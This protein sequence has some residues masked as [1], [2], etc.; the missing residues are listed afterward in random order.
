MIYLKH[1]E[2]AHKKQT[3]REEETVKY[4]APVFVTPL[5]DVIINEGERA[6]FEA[7]IQPVGDPNM[8]VDWFC[9]GKPITASSRVNTICQFG[10]VA[11]D[12]L[13]A[14]A[15]DSG[16]YTCEIRNESGAVHTSAKLV[17]QTRREIDAEANAARQQTLKHTEMKATQEIRREVREPPPARPEFVRQ[18]EAQVDKPE[19]GTIHLEAQVNP[20]SDHTMKIEWLKDGK[21]ITASSRIGTIFSFGYVSLNVTNLRA[22]DAGTYVCK[23]INASGQAQSQTQVR[24]QA[25]TDL[26]SSTGIIEQEQYIQ[27]TH[28]L[29]QQQAAKT[30]LK[31]SESI[32]EPTQPPEFKTPIKDQLQ[33]REGGF[34]HFEA[35][36]EPIVV[37]S[38]SSPWEVPSRRLG[39]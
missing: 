22:E 17:V 21:A 12:M 15:M 26:M 27:Q 7:K 38:P 19:G 6:K 8:R 5:R 4:G 2:Q 32:V 1:V 29:E 36:L 39:T 34:A 35:R 28:L 37:P 24:V 30:N 20:I 16:E 9:N 13:N 23:A 18:L 33:I 14:T 31:H 25:T 10:Y 3:K 11:L